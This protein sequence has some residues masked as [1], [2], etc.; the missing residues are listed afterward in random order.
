M[1]ARRDSSYTEELIKKRES[2][3][4]PLWG[5]FAAIML[6]LIAQGVPASYDFRYNDA[7]TLF[8]EQLDVL[9]LSAPV[10]AWYFLSLDFLLVAVCMLVGLYL[11]LV[12]GNNRL[13]ILVAFWLISWVATWIAPY[14]QAAQLYFLPTLI[15]DV[16]GNAIYATL[17]LT[18][19]SG[20]LQAKWVRWT[21]PIGIVTTFMITPYNS[22][23]EQTVGTSA[24]LFDFVLYSVT[25]GAIF[26]KFYAI[27]IILTSLNVN[28]Q[29]G[30]LLVF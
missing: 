17:L 23:L 24:T 2:W 15:I 28:N 16:M 29:N 20:R 22:W 14:V 12:S 30:F 8:P 26:Y 6:F 10:Y 27:V 4:L 1:Q 18:F 19:P 21:L 3:I 13:A 7:I 11:I 9:G 5:I 25:A